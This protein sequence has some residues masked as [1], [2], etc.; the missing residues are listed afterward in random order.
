MINVSVVFG[1]VSCEHDISILTGI[2]V[3][4]NLDKDKYNVY[5]IYINKSGEWIYS[6]NFVDVES[7]IKQKN[8]K[9]C[10]LLPNDTHLH[11]VNS[12]HVI[13]SIASIDVCL[14]C[15]HGVNGEDGSLFKI[16]DMSGIVCANSDLFSS[17]ICMDKCKFKKYA[18]S[19]DYVNVVKGVQYN[20]FDKLDDLKNNIQINNLAFPIIVKA[21]RQGSSIGITTSYNMDDL[22]N[23]INYCLRYDTE[24][25]LEQKLTN[26]IEYNIACYR[27]GK[28][29]ILSS[30]EQPIGK[31]EIL[32]YS[33][34]YLSGTKSDNVNTGMASLT[35][36]FPA[37]IGKN[38]L[39]KL[40]CTTER[41]YSDLGLNGV[42]RFDYM[43][44]KTNKKLYLNEVNTIPG[45]YA[46]YL[47]DTITFANLLDDIIE[48][49]YFINQQKN[50][51]I[52]YFES[53]VLKS[54][55]TGTKKIKK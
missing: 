10:F 35:R 37:K 2:Q 6:P 7:L 48:N 21:S 47:F 50:N 28:T 38:L 54:G 25:V 45:S 27:K 19:L 55:A 53:S 29:I 31:D 8:V 23:K 39:Q 43:Y 51:I 32:S 11:T 24:V 26:M 20:S 12:L 16:F 17:A 34:K 42:V 14:L 9:R 22:E 15:M 52:T 41:L 46:Y 36:I 13:K 3:I 1:G 30:V 18:D 5:P 4:N 40:Q 49:A 44:D 33:D